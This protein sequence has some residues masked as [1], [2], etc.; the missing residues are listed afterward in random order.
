MTRYF[1]PVQFHTLSEPHRESTVRAGSFLL[2]AGESAV[3]SIWRIKN[4]TAQ[5]VRNAE[6]FSNVG[7][8]LEKESLRFFRN[9][10]SFI[11][12]FGS[13]DGYMRL[14]CWHLLHFCAPEHNG[15][16]QANSLGWFATKEFTGLP[17]HA[18]ATLA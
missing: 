15:C 6:S 1:S 8:Q 5:R 9:Q 7:A 3:N 17:S 13:R 12:C 4:R 18:A 2:R 16:K 10:S 11:G 14:C